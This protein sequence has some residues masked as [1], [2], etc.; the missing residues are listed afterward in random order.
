LTVRVDFASPRMLVEKLPSHEGPGLLGVIASIARGKWLLS[1]Q[2]EN[3]SPSAS[4]YDKARLSSHGGRALRIMSS[5]LPMAYV[6]NK[7]KFLAVTS[8]R[9]MLIS[10]MQ[11]VAQL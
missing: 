2:Q 8:N 4:L 9:M 11:G 7:P 10:M 3:K 5:L 6:A 1:R